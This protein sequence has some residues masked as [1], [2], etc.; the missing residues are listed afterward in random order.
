MCNPRRQAHT[1]EVHVQ[2]SSVV[3][4]PQGPESSAASPEHLL[5]QNRDAAVSV[6]TCAPSACKAGKLGSLIACGR[7]YECNVQ[8]AAA[9]EPPEG[10]ESSAA[11]L[12]PELRNG[13][14]AVSV[15]TSA[16]SAVKAGKLAPVSEASP[17]AAS[18]AATQ[19]AP[20]SPWAEAQPSSPS[21]SRPGSPGETHSVT[22]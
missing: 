13:D 20:A 7:A 12:Q 16:P 19:A 22:D 5:L 1:D 4:P 10:P 15:S 6:L 17:L 8:A 14:A 3:E 2:G 18:P 9:P 21:F 11:D